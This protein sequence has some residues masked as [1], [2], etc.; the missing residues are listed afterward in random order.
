MAR[1]SFIHSPDILCIVDE[2]FMQYS[3][4]HSLSSGAGFLFIGISTLESMSKHIVSGAVALLM[5]FSPVVV[6]AQTIPDLP[7]NPTIEQLQALIVQLTQILAQLLQARSQ[8]SPFYDVSLSATAVTESTYNFNFNLG[9]GHS[10]GFKIDFGDGSN[11][12]LCAPYNCLTGDQQTMHGYTAPGTYTVSLIATLDGGGYTTVRTVTIQSGSNPVST[13]TNSVRITLP[14]SG[15]SFVQEQYIPITVTG[16][17]SR[18]AYGTVNVFKKV[19]GNWVSLSYGWPINASNTSIPTGQFSRNVPNVFFSSSA[20]LNTPPGEYGFQAQ[21]YTYGCGGYDCSPPTD[22]ILA[23]SDIVPIQI[24]G[25]GTNTTAG[26]MVISVDSSAPGYQVVPAGSTGVTMSAYKIRATGEAVNVNKIEMLISTDTAS[27]ND[28]TGFSLWNNGTQIGRGVFLGGQ[29]TA[30]VVL[31]QPLFVQKDAD[32]T[33]VVK[34]DIANIGIGQPGKAGDLLRVL[35]MGATGSGVTSGSNVERHQ[36]DAASTAIPGVRIF[37][38]FP[39]F[40][41]IPVPSVSGLADGKLMR[42]SVTA[43][44]AGPVMLDQFAINIAGFVPGSSGGNVADLCFY[45]YT[46]SN[47][48]VPMSSGQVG[49]LSACTSVTGNGRFVAGFYEAGAGIIPAGQTHY[50][51]LRDT[52]G[53][54]TSDGVLN[55]STIVTTLLGDSS[56]IPITRLGSAQTSG[57][58]VLFAEDS[59]TNVADVIWTNGYGLPGLPASGFSQTRTGTGISPANTPSCSITTDKSSYN[60]G[61]SIRFSWTSSYATYGKFVPDTSGKDN[62]IVPSEPLASSGTVSIP[63]SVYGNPFVTIR[64]YSVDGQSNTCTKIVPVAAPLATLPPSCTTSFSP[65][66]IAKGGVLTVS[67]TAQNAQSRSYKLYD[68]SGTLFFT[69]QSIAPNGSLQDTSYSGLSVGTSH[70]VDIVTATSGAT[71]TCDS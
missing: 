66:P 54:G 47:F 20:A 52:R 10:T 17:V 46:D 60:Y 22:R 34:G 15:A 55:A 48:S 29:N 19:S 37:K 9:T 21:L 16:S 14:A 8:Q 13:D 56:P 71:A 5:V 25:T 33:I 40:S 41:S 49:G 12:L 62:L 61:E 3:L 44:P 67:W 1:L 38:S 51:E 70:R 59:Y 11:M 39:T 45:E 24:T 36:L 50:F 28:L 7:A 42:F 57:S 53:R 43:N 27:P 23:T 64:V 58:N 18:L 31:T 65:N 35:M 69:S 30:T 6:S 4:Y 26:A 68:P 2:I 32:T 63:A